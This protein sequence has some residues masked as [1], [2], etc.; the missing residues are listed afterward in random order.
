MLVNLQMSCLNEESSGQVEGEPNLQFVGKSMEHQ[1]NVS[2][3]SKKFFSFYRYFNIVEP[4]KLKTKQYH[5]PEKR[6]ANF[7]N[8]NHQSK[9]ERY[10]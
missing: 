3:K 8:F 6:N 1:F 7:Y 9:V 4:H 10:T 2:L 5:D